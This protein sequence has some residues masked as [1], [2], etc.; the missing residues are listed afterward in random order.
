MYNAKSDVTVVV[1]EVSLGSDLDLMGD[2][3]QLSANPGLRQYK[4]NGE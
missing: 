1:N 2:T 3:N 4:K